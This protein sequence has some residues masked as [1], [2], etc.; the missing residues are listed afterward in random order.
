ML[1]RVK[2]LEMLAS[3]LLEFHVLHSTDQ[4][5]KRLDNEIAMLTAPKLSQRDVSSLF[6]FDNTSDFELI[7]RKGSSG[8]VVHKRIALPRRYLNVKI[9]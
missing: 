3:Q 1:T 7:V 4:V 9:Q 2:K 8:Q 5:Y 6:M